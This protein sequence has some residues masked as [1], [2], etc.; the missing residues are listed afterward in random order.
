[1]AVMVMATATD[2]DITATATD[3]AAMGIAATAATTIAV[4]SRCPTCLL[5]P[6]RGMRLCPTP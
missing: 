5:D 4:K 2:I 1:M 3:I 6:P